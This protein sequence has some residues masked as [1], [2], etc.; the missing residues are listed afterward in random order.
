M[1]SDISRH[2]DEIVAPSLP[3]PQSQPEYLFAIAQLRGMQPR[4]AGQA[5]VLEVGC[6]DGGNLIPTAER[7]PQGAFLGIDD[8][9]RQIE[10][11]SETAA[12]VGLSNVEF[13]RLGMLEFPDDAGQFDYIIAPGVYSWIDAAARDKL[14]AVCRK[15]L[16]PQGV[17]YVDYHV[18]P[19]WQVH[20]LLRSMM[21]YEGRGAE[22]PAQRLAAARVLLE[23]LKASLPADA[24]GYAALVRPA[25]ESLL[26]EDDAFLLRNYLQDESQAVYFGEFAAHAGRHGMQILGDCGLGIRYS[27]S[28]SPHCERG[29]RAITADPVEQE[30]FRDI[31]KNRVHRQS[32][33][34]HDALA[35]QHWPGAWR[36]GGLYLEARLMSQHGDAQIEST[37]AQTFVTPS[38]SNITTAV[39]TIKAALA[40]LGSLWPSYVTYEELVAAACARVE[41]RGGYASPLAPADVK[42]LEDN[43][44]ACCAEGIIQV[45]GAPQPFV[46]EASQQPQSSP[47]ARW[48]AARGELVTN[49]KHLRVRLDPFDR[50]VLQLA[51]GTRSVPQLVEELSTAIVQRHMAALENGKPVPPERLQPF[52]S[53]TLG[54]S[55][56][57]LVDNALLIA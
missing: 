26:K 49:R 33:L 24:G 22:T 39:P 19:G 48:Q 37:D 10:A 38:G 54:E 51:N 36:L 11:A 50:Y 1:R 30:Q 15:H 21:R 5:R 28:L 17:A 57:R 31:V 29:L 53:N 4:A 9:S 45:H 2:V 46:G 13:R 34:C 20:D 23:F 47:L 12:A 3:V 41:G 16:A 27:D 7:H 40:H 14:L 43:L 55:L 6:G 18:L 25:V 52:L 42:K 32:L 8:S 44:L 56:K 35:L